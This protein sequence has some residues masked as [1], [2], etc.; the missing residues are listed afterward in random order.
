MTDMKRTTG[1]L[2]EGQQ[3]SPMPRDFREAV[4]FFKHRSFNAQMAES[5]GLDVASDFVDPP[6]ELAQ[7]F[8]KSNSIEV[9]DLQRNR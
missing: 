1:G 5:L 6:S 3:K 4:Q 7:S 8:G 9:L 2:Y